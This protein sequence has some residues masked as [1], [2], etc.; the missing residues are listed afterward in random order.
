MVLERCRPVQ[1]LW[2]PYLPG[3]CWTP[4]VEVATTVYSGGET[5]KFAY[6]L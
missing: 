6:L 1:K 5:D 4:A 3:T 2:N